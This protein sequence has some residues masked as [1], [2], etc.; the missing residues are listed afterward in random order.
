MTE[1]PIFLPALPEIFLACATLGILLVGIFLNSAKAQPVAHGLAL[2]ALVVT[3]AL[4]LLNGGE[5]QLAMNG[6]F[7]AD[8]FARYV[9]LLLLAASV[10]VLVAGQAYVREKMNSFEYPV[11]VCMAVLGMMMMVSANNLMSLYLG[12]ELQSLSLY[13]VAAFRR[14]SSRASEA[15]LKYFVLG[16]VSSG[17]L[18]YGCSLIY[19]YTG[20]LDF[21]GLVYLLDGSTPVSAGVVTGLM[22][23]LA[24]LAFKVSAV[25]FHMWT[26]DVYEGAPTPVTAFF[27]AAPKIAA[28]ALLIRV[29]AGPFQGMLADWRQVIVLLSVLSMLLGA[30]AAIAQTD[31]K[32][33]L[34]YSSIGHAGYALIGLAAGTAASVQAVLVYLA[35]YMFMTVGVF[36][37]LL[38][39]RVNGRTV[40]SLAELAGLKTEKPLVAA[41]LMILMFSM[42]GIPPMAG[43]IGK[44]VIFKAA[45][46][47][48]LTLLAVVGALASVVSAYYYLRIVKVMYFD[49][50]AVTMERTPGLW[51]GAVIA[52]AGFFCVSFLLYV[53][54]VSVPAARASQALFG[55]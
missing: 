12:L 43:F 27:A 49:A 19:G 29:L 21:D 39:L 8:S 25:P 44:F 48:G 31:L 26:P 28:I 17:M 3:A 30:F 50:P 37:C 6:L 14:D 16:A 33:L 22:F 7:I 42:A 24:G 20:T 9:K 35:V 55:G 1:L 2:V 4:L 23:L 52:V 51:N 32:R 11:L 18:L 38:A 45:V 53:P 15:G 5:R 36:A 54:L 41:A 34:A 13:V 10:M 47:A 46:D 40:R